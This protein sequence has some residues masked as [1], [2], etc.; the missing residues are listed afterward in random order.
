MSTL[1]TFRLIAAGAAALA[2]LALMFPDANPNSP[3]R[4]ALIGLLTG[5]WALLTASL[6]PQGDVDRITDRLTGVGI[7]VAVL[8]L[9]AAI[10]V[11]LVNRFPTL[12]F[13]LLAIALPIRLPLNIGS[14]SAN[15]LLPLYCVII[16]GVVALIVR[17]R[18]GTAAAS[19]RSAWIA[20]PLGAFVIVTLV[21]LTWTSDWTEAT[22]KVV[23]FYLPFILLF[24][25]VGAWWPLAQQPLRPIAATTVTIAVATALIALLQFATRSIWW[26]TTLKQ[27]NTYNRFF[28]TNGIFF[29]PNIL[30]RFL[31]LAIIVALAYLVVTDDRVQTWIVATAIVVIAAGLVVTFSRSSALMLL[32]G[33]VI[34]GIRAFGAVKTI[35]VTI[36]AVVLTA[37]PAL[38]LSENVRDKT[39]SMVG[40]AKASE[41][42]AR[43]VKGGVE[44]WR[45]E[46]VRGVGIGS[47]AQRYAETLPARERRRTR[48]VISH[49]API[50]V[51][52]ELGLVGV[53]FFAALILGTFIGLVRGIRRG[54][55][56]AMS[57]IT[58]LAALGGILV[59]SVLYSAFFEDP[60]VWVLLAAGAALC[61]SATG[62][63]E[64]GDGVA[65]ELPAQ[66]G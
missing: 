11:V 12:W 40:I 59:H 14:Q 52:A 63:S 29:D 41:G 37:G 42:R 45:Q 5:A 64:I 22:A 3:R 13:V 34:I 31:A 38:A 20:V 21:S 1:E 46:P 32:V 39:T 4:S 48:V 18:R 35:T 57:L 62:R 50:T 65:K 49:T 60:Y 10:A 24:H 19:P 43:L 27:G 15:L 58:I 30:G 36:A 16:V 47:F 51:L 2:V 53:G 28:R 8:A 25:L 54:P 55:A 44:L 26:N 7:L 61:V 9:A 23:F 33:L 6:I 66:V 56:R 17:S